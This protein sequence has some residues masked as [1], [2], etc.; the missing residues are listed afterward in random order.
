MRAL[1]LAL[2]LAMSGHLTSKC[3]ETAVATP[4]VKPTALRSTDPVTQQGILFLPFNLCH[5]LLHEGHVS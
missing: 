5:I 1:L 3:T 4:Q 2:V